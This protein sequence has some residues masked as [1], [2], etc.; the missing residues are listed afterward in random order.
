MDDQ[1]ELGGDLPIASGAV[2]HDDD[3]S[4]PFNT[5]HAKG[6]GRADDSGVCASIKTSLPTYHSIPR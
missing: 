5:G 4:Q 3:P 6:K 1:E 2:G